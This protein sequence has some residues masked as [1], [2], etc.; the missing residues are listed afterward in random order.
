M[1]FFFWIFHVLVKLNVFFT[2]WNIGMGII[3]Y[4][5]MRFRYMR[6]SSLS[7]IN[8]IFLLC[9]TFHFCYLLYMMSF[10][11]WHTFQWL[12][13][14]CWRP[15]CTSKQ[16][17]VTIWTS[18]WKL[19]LVRCSGILIIVYFILVFSS[20]SISSL[21]IPMVKWVIFVFT[22]LVILSFCVLDLVWN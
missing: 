15:R 8:F 18:R 9:I 16:S 11:W 3:W 6:F 4:F 17:Q 14:T 10:I 20:G 22:L 5:I 19:N 13:I 1:S 12:V 2:M 7:W 21:F